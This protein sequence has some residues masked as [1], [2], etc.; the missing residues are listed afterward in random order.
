MLSYAPCEDKGEG[1]KGEGDSLYAREQRH[2]I[3]DVL[4]P[5]PCTFPA[6]RSLLRDV[7]KGRQ[8]DG[9]TY[10][11]AHC[12][13]MGARQSPAGPEVTASLYP[14]ETLTDTVRLTPAGR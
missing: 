6:Q 12:V 4:A 5:R 9:V 3:T 1:D 8:Q 13:G 2:E 11:K 7:G 10:P 14:K